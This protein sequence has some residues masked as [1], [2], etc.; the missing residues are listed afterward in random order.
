MQPN[1]E[2]PRELIE[3][4]LNYWFADLSDESAISMEHPHCKI[5]YVKDKE[6]DIEIR[7]LFYGSYHKYEGMTHFAPPDGKAAL[8]V[9]L[10]FDQF[11]HHM[12]RGTK[13]MYAAAETALEVSKYALDKEYDLQ[14]S[15]IQRLFLYV[16]LM[17]SEVLQ[18]QEDMLKLFENL[19]KQAKT[20]AT[21][22]V[23]FFEMA[24][25]YYAKKHYDIVARF[26]RFPHR[27]EL[28]GRRSTKEELE[29]LEVDESNF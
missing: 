5:W 27:N 20:K 26:G 18:D 19:S 15:L 1:L 8:A 28:L 9:V 21:K 4:V 29:F 22:S 25:S 23:E 10:L 12:F 14:L 2:L 11:P 7:S 6:V 24:Y 16:P 17:H 13:K 3:H